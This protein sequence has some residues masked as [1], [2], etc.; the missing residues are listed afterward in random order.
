MSIISRHNSEVTYSVEDA[1]FYS[2]L[3]LL[4]GRTEVEAEATIFWPPD[5][6]SWLI[7]KDPDVGKD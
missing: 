7:G 6:N 2:F 1:I 5:V 3:L 4:L